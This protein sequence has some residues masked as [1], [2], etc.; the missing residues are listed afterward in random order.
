MSVEAIFF[1]FGGVLLKHADGIDHKAIEAQFDLPER[2]V[3]N[4]LYRDSRYKDFFV[5]RCTEQEWVESIREAA[6][7]NVGD[8]ARGMLKALREADSELNLDMVRLMERLHGRYRLGII[9]NTT[10]GME[11]RLQTQFPQLIELTEARV[12][13]GDLKIAKPDPEI[14][15]HATNQMGVSLE[16]SVF[17]DDTASY[18]LAASELGMHGIHFTDYESFVAKLEAIGVAW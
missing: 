1:D 7:R 6:E 4:C 9:S 17:T 2:S 15:H 3:F 18:A 11:E 10:P 13:S 5:G 8:K 16:S 14:F 12:G